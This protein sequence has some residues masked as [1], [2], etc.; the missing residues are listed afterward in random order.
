VAQDQTVVDA[1]HSC[2]HATKAI[3]NA[4]RG[5]RKGPGSRLLN[6][7]LRARVP[8][9]LPT[10]NCSLST[11]AV[12]ENPEEVAGWSR[13]IGVHGRVKLLLMLFNRLRKSQKG[14]L[15]RQWLCKRLRSPW[16][17]RSIESNLFHSRGC[18]G[19]L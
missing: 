8:A 19:F 15:S 6:A 17:A 9:A 16:F 10:A 2:D 12:R 11:S 13:P 18:N 3:T 7:A 5:R 1:H 4:N 14:P